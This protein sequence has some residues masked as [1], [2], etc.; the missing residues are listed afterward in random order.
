MDSPRSPD[1][2]EQPTFMQIL[3]TDKS[4][5]IRG[6]VLCSGNNHDILD[7]WGFPAI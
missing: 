4:P 6:E 2:N 5:E 7:R 3:M 1:S